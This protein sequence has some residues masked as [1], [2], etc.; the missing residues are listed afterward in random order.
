MW[1]KRRFT[2]DEIVE[3]NKYMKTFFFDETIESSPGQFAMVFIPGIGEK[4]FSLSS[5]NSITVEKRGKFT[6]KLFQ[7]KPK[8]FVYIKGP[9]GVG[10]R[11]KDY[12]A[13][14][15][16]SGIAPMLYLINNAVIKSLLYGAR[17]N[18]HLIHG[19]KDCVV[20]YATD[21]GSYGYHGFV[22]DLITED[23]VSQH[24][25]FAI[26][27]PEIMMKIAAE[28]LVELG[29][30]PKDIELSLERMFWKKDLYWWSCFHIWWNFRNARFC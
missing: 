13:V 28:K 18:E 15:G 24:S 1:I 2:I 29:V 11:N 3:H 26:C 4:P 27:G 23:L 6:Q 12:L 20:Y 5:K 7:M 17:D 30:E 19:I 21:D 16:G 9:L 14:A 10:F 25:K 22:T 8:D